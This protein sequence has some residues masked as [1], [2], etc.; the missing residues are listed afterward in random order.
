MRNPSKN[1]LK[2]LLRV[3]NGSPTPGWAMRKADYFLFNEVGARAYIMSKGKICNR[4]PKGYERYLTPHCKTI[5]QNSKLVMYLSLEF[6]EPTFR[7]SRLTQD[8]KDAIRDTKYNQFKQTALEL[9]MT[10]CPIPTTAVKELQAD[11]YKP[12]DYHSL[13]DK[14]HYFKVKLVTDNGYTV[15]ALGGHW[16]LQVGTDVWLNFYNLEEANTYIPTGLEAQRA[17]QWAFIDHPK[18]IVQAVMV[19]KEIDTI[20]RGI[21]HEQNNFMQVEEP[22]YF[23]ISL[24]HDSRQMRTTLDTL[25]QDLQTLK[26]EAQ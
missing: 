17:M 26:D 20:V 5:Y 2:T 10:I 21:N 19:D 7:G 13:I 6:I 18:N 4:Q 14:S 22:T 1:T 23:Y 24:E 9:G 15:R 12:T 11:N 3:N 8:K 25:E 16:Q